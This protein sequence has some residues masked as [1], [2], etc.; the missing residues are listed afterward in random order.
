M[1]FCFK[2]CDFDAFQVSWAPSNSGLVPN[3]DRAELSATEAM[4]SCITTQHLCAN[5]KH[6]TI[7]KVL[8]SWHHNSL[9]Y[10]L[11]TLA[12]TTRSTFK[13]LGVNSFTLMKLDGGIQAIPPPHL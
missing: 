2:H 6:R 5:S 12:F 7:W 1:K 9:H 11:L 10:E 8:I 4:Q 13:E 3:S